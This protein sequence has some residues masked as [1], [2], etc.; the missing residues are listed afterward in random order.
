M[1]GN[2]KWYQWRTQC[3]LWSQS[4]TT[5]QVL[6]SLFLQNLQYNAKACHINYLKYFY[7]DIKIFLSRKR[8]L[9]Y[10]SLKVHISFISMKLK[11]MNGVLKVFTFWWTSCTEQWSRYRKLKQESSNPRFSINNTRYSWGA[12]CGISYLK[13]TVVKENVRRSLWWFMFVVRDI[14]EGDLTETKV[15]SKIVFC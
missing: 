8:K 15:M 10:V 6:L 4:P 14:T 1:C 13:A 7:L 11:L 3:P 12:V 2:W 5:P 9:L